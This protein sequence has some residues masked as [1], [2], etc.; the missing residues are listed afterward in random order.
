[1]KN[2]ETISQLRS[3]KAET[4]KEKQNLSLYDH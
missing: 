2:A 4:R 3:I 1:M